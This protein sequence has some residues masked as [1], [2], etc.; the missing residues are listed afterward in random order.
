MPTFVAVLAGVA[1]ALA[2]GV[3]ARAVRRVWRRRRQV[4]LDLTPWYRS[5]PGVTLEAEERDP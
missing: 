3:L 2:F 4:G 5:G 1:G